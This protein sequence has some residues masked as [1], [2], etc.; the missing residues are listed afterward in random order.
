[1]FLL[2]GYAQGGDALIGWDVEGGDDDGICFEPEKKLTVSDWFP[3]AGAVVLLTGKHA[4]PAE[5][6]VYREAL[7]QGAWLLRVR[8]SGHHH[9]GPATFDAWAKSL[10]DPSLSAD[11]PATAKRRNELLDPMVWDL[12]T[13]RHYGALFLIRAAELFPKAASDLQAAAACFRAEHDMMWEVNRVGGGQWPGDKLPKLA[14]PA[15]R[16]QIAELLLKSR[17]KDLEAAESIER[18]LRAAAD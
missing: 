18:A 2:T 16:K 4:R 3:K 10:D 5:Q 13:R 8:E 1:M 7:R 15:V 12:A 6:G 11:D 9:A 14:D 17:D